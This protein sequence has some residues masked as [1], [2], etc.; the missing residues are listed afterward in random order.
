[1]CH[2]QTATTTY[3]PRDYSPVPPSPG[4]AALM[5]YND[6]P[7]NHF[8]GLPDISFPV[9][10]LQEG[11]LS[12]PITLSYH[13]GGIRVEERETSVGLGWSL[14]AGGAISRTVYGHPDDAIKLHTDGKGLRGLLNQTTAEKEMRAFAISTVADYDPADYIYYDTI[15]SCQLSLGGSYNRGE[16]D[17]ANDIF[18]INCMGLSGTFIYD[19]NHN[20]I[21]SSNN[22]YLI[23][24]SHIINSYPQQ[25]IISDV[26]GTKYYFSESEETK[27][28]YYTGTSPE[29][30]L[31]D[32]LYYTSAWH[33]TKIKNIHNDSIVFKYRQCGKTQ[34]YG[35]ISQVG[36][37]VNTD[38]LSGYVPY[39]I[40]SR[41]DIEYNQ[42]RLEQIISSTAIVTFIHTYNT[43]IQTDIITQITIKTNTESPQ[44]VKEY[45]LEYNL[46]RNHGSDPDRNRL[47]LTTISERGIPLYQ[48]SYY[49]NI[50]GSLSFA[51][52]DQ[53]FAGYYNAAQNVNLISQY[54]DTYGENSD[55][56]PNPNVV[57]H[58]SL[59]T[60]EY[61]TGGKVEL[62]WESHEYGKVNDKTVEVSYST[63]INEIKYDTLIGL[64]PNSVRKLQINNFEV[65]SNYEVYLDLTKYFNFD[66]T[67]LYGSEFYYEHTYD[68]SLIYPTI[69]FINNETGEQTKA[70]TYYLD[71]KTIY[72]NNGGNIHVP[73]TVGTYTVELRHPTSISLGNAQEHLAREFY[74]ADADCGKI[75]IRRE[76]YGS[77]SGN[78][79][80]NKKLW[81]GARIKRIYSYVHS[82]SIPIIKDYIYGNMDPELSNG[83]APCNPAFTSQYY[84][85][86]Q[87]FQTPGHEG[88]MVYATSSQG[89][90]NLPVGTVGIEYPQV[91]ERFSL[92]D[93]DDISSELSSRVIRYNYSSIATPEYRDYNISQFLNCQPTGQ[94]IWTS[95]AHHRGNLTGKYY[96]IAGGGVN[97]ES[98]E[99]EYN[100]YEPEEYSMF[101]TD[102]FRTADIQGQYDYC[103]GKYYLIPYNKTIKEEKINKYDYTQTI[104]YSYFYD[105][106]TSNIDY[107]LVKSQQTTESNG[108]IKKVYY[109]YL[110]VNGQ[111]LN[112]PETEVTVVNNLIIDAKRMEYYSGSYRLKAVYG[113]SKLREEALLYSLGGKSASQT[114]ISLISR[115]EYSYRYNDCDN[116]IEIRYN[117]EV[118]ASY[119]WGYK[120]SHPIVEVKNLAYDELLS[121]MDSL[122]KSPSDLLENTD[123]ENLKTFYSQLRAALPLH[124]VVTM[125]YHWLI[126]VAE[127]TDAR[128]VTT[129]YT[130]DDWGRLTDVKDHNRYYIRKY[131]YHYKE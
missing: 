54:L 79:N 93:R 117:G 119:L 122:G 12:V 92:P 65:K 67:L 68:P 10:T 52:Y 8:S 131:D 107:G 7:V 19:D 16:A 118:L 81:G 111:H 128:G 50:D 36:Y 109:T 45:D 23:S 69:V 47:L 2:G 129:Y 95:R 71:K 42:L 30:M 55:R 101:T 13:G 78:A 46:Y 14:I 108:S 124:N 32:S 85:V 58:G 11:S 31:L 112:I 20:A 53:D 57:M 37:D 125:A 77:N 83:I 100:I 73:I 99:Y 91:I 70:L 49:A 63:Y 105:S 59:K 80:V 3:A 103:I 106:Y 28:K 6:I 89:L 75:L 94:Q 5:K 88:G 22:A 39:H 40:S 33:L 104:K 51:T 21:L 82:D 64:L 60:I 26:G 110:N 127:A 41:G 115:P 76:C 29:N 84:M 116:L 98:T 25:F 126:G 61:P 72:D 113:L 34:K 74:H 130:Y 123:S 87:N 102:L 38:W 27:Y 17:M 62:E 48:F 15:R 18:K 9:F 35:A 43:D 96:S 86:R 56:E 44:V 97:Y 114:L 24:P 4:V 120:G 1:M 90:Y 121:V 66:Y